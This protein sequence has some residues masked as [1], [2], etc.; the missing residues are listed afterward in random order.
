MPSAAVLAIHD[1]TI[2][3]G[4]SIAV[5]GL[6]LEVRRGEVVGL[7]GP[8]GS[9]KS[10]TIAAVAGLLTPHEGDVRVLGLCHRT[11]PLAC[12]RAI[13]LVP[14][15]LAFYE[16]L[17]AQANLSFFGRLY[18]MRGRHLRQ[19]VAEALDFVCLA[20]RASCPARTLSGGMQRRLNLACALLHEPALLLL[21]EPTVGLDVQSR[22]AIFSS[23]RALRARG[24][25]LVF[26]THHLEEA[27]RLCDRVTILDRGRLVAAGTVAELCRGWDAPGWRL[28]G[29]HGR[30]GRPA[31]LERVYREL[32]G[33]APA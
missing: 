14:Q 6:C 4:P 13:G 3:Y 5:D 25:A 26:T 17:S 1:L 2:R 30:R 27:E 9:G 16:D 8:N 11:D 7:L 18:G 23:L 33:G 10:S 15:E 21:D 29:P 32:T 22:D 20:E 12:R 24:H 31:D 28:D 19:R